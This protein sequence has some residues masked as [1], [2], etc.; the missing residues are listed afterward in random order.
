MCSQILG[1]ALR[2]Q[3]TSPPLLPGCTTTHGKRPRCMTGRASGSDNASERSV[4]TTSERPP[5]IAVNINLPQRNPAPPPKPVPIIHSATYLQRSYNMDDAQIVY[6][7]ASSS[8]R[9]SSSMQDEADGSGIEWALRRMDRSL[10]E[11]EQNPSVWQKTVYDIS[12]GPVGEATTKSMEA[13]A[14]LTIK[15]TV[16]AAKA[17]APVGQW[18]LKEGAKAAMGLFKY[19]MVEAAKREEKDKGKG[20]GTRKIK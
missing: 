1:S 12:K 9:S 5:P 16:T 14:K 10:D 8:A 6:E 13:A 2:K 7:Q 20:T 18:A 4:T 17:A 11:M 3:V 15:A 19:A